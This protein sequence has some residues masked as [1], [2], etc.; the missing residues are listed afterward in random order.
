MAF[1]HLSIAARCSL[2]YSQN[3]ALPLQQDVIV[4]QGRGHLWRTVPEDGTALVRRRHLAIK[5]PVLD[6]AISMCI[7][8][9]A[10]VFASRCHSDM[11][12]RIYRTSIVIVEKWNQLANS[13]E[14][15]PYCIWI[16]NDANCRVLR[17]RC[18]KAF[19]QSL[20]DLERGIHRE[21]VLEWSESSDQ[22][23]ELLSRVMSVGLSSSACA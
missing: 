14:G 4:V 6:V 16:R 1:L 12:H 11:Q 21:L 20:R 9:K 8:L 22:Y 23:R 13:F 2:R 5:I 19:G 17:R 3:I 15:H 7:S 18:R 10:V